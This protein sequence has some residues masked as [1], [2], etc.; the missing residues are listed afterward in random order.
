MR[1]Y[2]DD[3]DSDIVFAG[4]RRCWLRRADFDRTVFR[5]AVDRN[6]Q[7]PEAAVPIQP[8]RQ[9]LT[10][11]GLRHSHKTW[12][13]ADGIPEIAQAR[14]LGHRLDNRIVE[15]YSHVAPEVERRLLRCLERRWWKARV[16]VDRAA[17]Q[18]TPPREPAGSV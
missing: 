15:T 7:W 3:Q 1:D 6:L 8:A 11:H 14:R 9:R 4:P 17:T 18:L 12:M 13:I 16:V 5:P 2:F 10:F